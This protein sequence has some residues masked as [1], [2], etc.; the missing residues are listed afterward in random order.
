MNVARVAAV[1]AIMLVGTACA[2]DQPPVS[3][4]AEDASAA[5]DAYVTE[6]QDLSASYQRVLEIKV[7]DIIATAGDEAVDRA[8]DLVRT[9]TIEFLSLLGDA[10]DRYTSA[11]TAIPTPPAVADERDMYVDVLATANT[12][13]PDMRDAVVTSAT[14]V[15]IQRALVG[16]AY[17][18]AQL[19]LV[20]SC[21]SLEQAVRDAGHGID[22]KCAPT[23]LTPTGSSP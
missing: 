4:F 17:A 10:L 12:A 23:E 2:A 11:V 15:D 19:R 13:L 21:E 8:T 16:S 6:A 14:I 22:L 3:G 20:A 9:E 5:A 18:D 1:T 7:A